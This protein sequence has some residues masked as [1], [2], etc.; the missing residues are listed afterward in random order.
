MFMQSKPRKI[1]YRVPSSKLM[2]SP[3]GRFKPRA[4]HLQAARWPP[5]AQASLRCDD[6]RRANPIITRPLRC[7]GG[8]RGHERRLGKLSEL[9]V[10]LAAVVASPA[11]CLRYSLEVLPQLH[12]LLI[13]GTLL[14]LEAAHD[15]IEHRKGSLGIPLSLGQAG[16]AVDRRRRHCGGSGLG[17]TGLADV[18]GDGGG[19]QVVH[20]SERHLAALASGRGFCRRAGPRRQRPRLRSRGGA[21]PGGAAPAAS[22]LRRHAEARRGL[23]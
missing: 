23:R 18:N 16:V 19:N 11:H 1:A 10:G 2:R 12:G 6:A 4:C 21:G 5:F 7:I 22:R 17:L 3:Q 14:C 8:G 9:P 13:E 20:S 15:H